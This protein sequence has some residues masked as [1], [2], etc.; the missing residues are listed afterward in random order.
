MRPFG[1][2]VEDG[3]ATRRRAVAARDGTDVGVERRGPSG[4]WRDSTGRGAA[5]RDI[6]LL[7]IPIQIGREEGGVVG[8]VGCGCG[9][10]VRVCGVR[11]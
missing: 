6:G 3:R 7:W 5:S 1:E 4:V 11:G 8:R 10:W 9:E 2:E